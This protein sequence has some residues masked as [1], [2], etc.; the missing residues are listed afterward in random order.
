MAS[1]INRPDGHRWIQFVGA[2]GR[3][4]TIRLGR[5]K[6]KNAAEVNRRV[7]L[8][9]NAKDSG[10]SLDA[11]TA[12]WLSDLDGWL[13][14]RLAVLGLAEPRAERMRLGEFLDTYI[15][16]RKDL[17]PA[18]RTV[19]GHTRRCLIE[20]FGAD[21]SLRSITLGDADAWRVWLATEG[22]N[23]DTE[24]DELSENTVR[25]RCGIAKQ[26][27]R[28]AI[29]LRMLDANPFS[30]LTAQVRGN[31]ARQQFVTRD[32][33]QKVMEAAPDHQWRT[34]IA[35]ARYGGLRVPSELL[36]LKLTDV[37]LPGGK[38][39]IRASKTEHHESGGVRVCPIFPELR[40]YL[41][42]IWD[43]A[44]PGT[45][46]VITRYRDTNAN[47][48]T[49]LLKIIARAGLK[50]WPKLFHNLRAT[51]QTELLNHFPIKAVCDWLGNSQ[52]VAIEH[53]AQVTAEH[54]QTAATEL[55]GAAESARGAS[56]TGEAESEARAKQNA[57]QQ[58][59]AVVGSDS[60]SERKKRPQALVV[61][62]VLQSDATAG[63]NAVNRAKVAIVGGEGLEPPTL[64]V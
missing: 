51:R 7:E 23:R 5:M 1:I 54:F 55:T 22:N 25:R 63:E 24:R 38:M 49:R 3:R 36:A 17:K 56:E 61:Q 47:L 39:T 41:E 48:R 43:E 26:F 59:S 35:L 12:K 10:S 57:K 27:F 19:L 15:A 50:P 37:D 45:E 9:L 4:F 14:D 60:H 64:S 42:R 33:I 30:E 18:T 40:P 53:Y 31:R 58:A 62:G 2:D 20:F 21:K 34:I 11:E 46:Y 8:L 29:K 13:R 28:A 52:P 44:P 6:A 16:G 32:E